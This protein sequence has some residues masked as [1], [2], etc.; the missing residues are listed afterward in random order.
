MLKVKQFNF[1]LGQAK[2]VR[3]FLDHLLYLQDILIYSNL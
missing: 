2:F 3:M 1:C